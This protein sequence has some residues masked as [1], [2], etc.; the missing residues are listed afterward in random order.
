MPLSTPGGV[1]F[2]L[3]IISGFITIL[4]AS[5]EEKFAWASIASSGFLALWAA[6]SVIITPIYSDFIFQHFAALA[7]WTL[8]YLFAFS[9]LL[10]FELYHFGIFVP[11]AINSASISVLLNSNQLHQVES[12]RLPLIR[13][14]LIGGNLFPTGLLPPPATHPRSL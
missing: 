7:L 14:G 12:R 11:L 9:R 3:Q 5:Q 1:L 13:R 8:A 10:N 6:T 4:L 2:I